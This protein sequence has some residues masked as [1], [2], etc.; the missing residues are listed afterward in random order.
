MDH[1]RII[2]KKLSE[3]NLGTLMKEGS[4]EFFTINHEEIERKHGDLG[5]KE[6]VY[7]S[8]THSHQ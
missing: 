2:C 8:C 1:V 5:I 4:Q 6:Q 3:K 7:Y